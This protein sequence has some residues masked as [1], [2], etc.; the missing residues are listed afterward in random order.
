MN[1]KKNGITNLAIIDSIFVLVNIVAVCFRYGMREN[2]LITFLWIKA[3]IIS[4]LKK[5]SFFVGFRIIKIFMLDNKQLRIQFFFF[6][7]E[8]IILI[9]TKRM[10]SFAK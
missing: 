3:S 2:H 9:R 6:P 8:D 7:L 4:V 5:Y 1:S 10:S